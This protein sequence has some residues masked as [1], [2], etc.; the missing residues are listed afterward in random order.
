MSESSALVPSHPGRARTV[1]FGDFLGIDADLFRV[2][3]LRRE[4]ASRRELGAPVGSGPIPDARKRATVP[5]V[6][7]NSLFSY[8]VPRYVRIEVSFLFFLFSD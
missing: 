1:D 6:A 4:P 7:L 3:S 2:L 5:F 8:T